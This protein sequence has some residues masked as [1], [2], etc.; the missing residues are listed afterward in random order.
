MIPDQRL[1]LAEVIRQ[2]DAIFRLEGFEPT[3]QH[4]MMD[5][6]LLSGC[7]T[8]AHLIEQMRGYVLQYGSLEGFIPVAVPS[9]TS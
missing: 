5:E 2:I 3:A 7:L 6:A 8:P 9:D 1:R 4:R